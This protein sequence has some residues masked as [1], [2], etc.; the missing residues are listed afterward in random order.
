MQLAD[1][2]S[3][4]LEA[5]NDHHLKKLAPQKDFTD[6]L[7]KPL[8]WVEEIRSK[9]TAYQAWNHRWPSI[10]T[11]FVVGAVGESDLELLGT[12]EHLHRELHLQRAYF[13][14]FHP[15]KD[16]PLEDTPLT[17]PVRE[18]RLY[19]SSFLIRDYGFSVEELPFDASGNLPLHLDP[20]L[21]WAKNNLLDKPVELNKAS[22]EELLRIPGIGPKAVKLL[23][24]N[25][26]LIHF[27]DISQL[28][29]LGINPTRAV[30]YILLDGK[31]PPYQNTFW[32]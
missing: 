17:S 6:E 20:K 30:P 24:Q 32:N 9:E 11:Q 1:R 18:R 7:L 28:S 4:N 27:K 13:S 2:L 8:K 29:K 16:T 31:R 5:P 23:I 12:T 14:A 3:I 10:V 25:R 19:Q 21:A 15:I 22:R 26:R